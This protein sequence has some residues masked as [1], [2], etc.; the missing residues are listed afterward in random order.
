[1]RVSFRITV[2][3]APHTRLRGSPKVSLPLCSHSSRV[4][5]LLDDQV[6]GTYSI[7][8]AVDTELLK[9]L[10]THRENK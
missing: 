10:Y 3:F 8:N 1:M 6:H 2:V 9:Q 7:T 5:T 4:A